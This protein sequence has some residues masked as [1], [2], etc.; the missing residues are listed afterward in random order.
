MNKVCNSHI[1][2]PLLKDILA[3]IIQIKISLH[4]IND[5]LSIVV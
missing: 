5:Y 2:N 1:K 3:Y 4:Y